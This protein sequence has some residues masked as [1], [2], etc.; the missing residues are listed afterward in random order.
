VGERRILVVGSQTSGR[1]K[2]SFLP[3]L[4]CRL[5]NI[6]INPD[7]G[8][9]VPALPPTGGW[10]PGLLL[11]PSASEARRAVEHAWIS[12]SNDEATLF[13]AFVGHGEFDGQHFYLLPM[14]AELDPLRPSTALNLVQHI[15]E[16]QPNHSNVDGLVVLVDAC[17]SGQAAAA[18]AR[19]W[20]STLADDL[21]YEVLTASADG[22][23]AGGCFTRTL[24]ALLRDGLAR[25]TS[26]VLRLEVAKA[27]VVERCQSQP[28]HATWNADPGL[29]LGY[30]AHLTGSAAAL[31]GTTTL[32]SVEE[33]TEWL[34]PTGELTQLVALARSAQ[35]VAVTG[36]AGSGKSTL[37]GAFAP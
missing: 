2:L 23:A 30:N 3:D 9:C 24:V 11:N 19:Q 21:R 29:F 34:Q 28:Q 22:P 31:A 36:V 5:Y 14:D 20:Q 33:L 27:V 10:D 18:A 25:A 17:Y 16:L 4:A 15:A 35:C 6:M 26:D 37:A 8:A 1:Q 7:R 13:L 32:G 12:A